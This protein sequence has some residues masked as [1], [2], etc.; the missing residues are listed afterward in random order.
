V[1]TDQIDQ[2][3]R[4]LLEREAGFFDLLEGCRRGLGSQ[5]AILRFAKKC[6]KTPE[7]ALLNA[8]RTRDPAVNRLYQNEALCIVA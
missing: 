7:R 2:L 8:L 5:A 6:G 4:P 3:L 1:H